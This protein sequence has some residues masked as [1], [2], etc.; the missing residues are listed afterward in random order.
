MQLVYCTFFL[1]ISFPPKIILIV[2][3]FNS[4]QPATRFIIKT[5]H[6]NRLFILPPCQITLIVM[7]HMN[8]WLVQNIIDEK[9]QFI[10]NIT[11]DVMLFCSVELEIKIGT[12]AISV[13]I[14]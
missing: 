5:W 10:L 8:M 9:S 12:I 11:V 4:L 1:F 14:V 6:F 13:K 2:F 3:H 7:T